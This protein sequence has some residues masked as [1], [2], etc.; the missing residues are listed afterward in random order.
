AMWMSVWTRAVIAPAARRAAAVWAGAII[1]AAVLF[2]PTGIQPRDITRLALGMPILGAILG[3]TWLLLFVPTARLIVRPDAARYLRALPGPRL[4]PVVVA[5]AALIALQLPWLVL[6]ALGDGARGLAIALGW[7]AAIAAIAAWRQRPARPRIP[8]WPSAT[9]GLRGIYVRALRRR[10]S[11]A[12]VRGAGNAV[13]AG[14]AAALLVHNNELAGRAAAA[15]AA[16][17]IAVALVPGWAGALVPLLDAHRACG[18][19]AATLGVSAPARAAVLAAAIAAVY[20]AGAAL[21][22]A[23]AAAVLGVLGTLDAATLGW[24]AIVTLASALG[25]ALIATRWVRAA[26]RSVAPAVRVVV[27]A[28][29]ASACAVLALALLGVPGAAATCATG[30]LALATGRA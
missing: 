6:W 18:W 25:A 28:V 21:A 30:A 14:L 17:A 2:G 13:L 4:A 1:V 7:T 16:S 8:R 15:L 19:L 11:D 27:G 9:A 20:V 12:L 26:E 5:I 22:V 24:L 3:V 10:A 29:L 23:A